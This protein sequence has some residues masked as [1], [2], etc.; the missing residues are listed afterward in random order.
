M[1][2]LVVFANDDGALTVHIC[3]R[4]CAPCRLPGDGRKQVRMF[5][6]EGSEPFF[7]TAQRTALE[8]AVA[9]YRS[10]SPGEVRIIGMDALLA[11]MGE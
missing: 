2:S 1:G 6:E 11:G 7:S 3:D 8:Y 4:S 9:C 10:L 5:Y